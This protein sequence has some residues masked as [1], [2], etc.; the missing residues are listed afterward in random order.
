MKLLILILPIWV[1]L[2][3]HVYQKTG[4]NTAIKTLETADSLDV[5][6]YELYIEYYSFIPDSIEVVGQIKQEDINWK[7]VEF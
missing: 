4:Q 2:N 6:P 3:C 5:L 7:E 1:I